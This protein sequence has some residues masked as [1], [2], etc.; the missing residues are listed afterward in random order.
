[1]PYYHRWVRHLYLL[2]LFLSGQTFADQ[3]GI[4]WKIEGK[5]AAPSYLLGTIHSE[6]PQVLQVAATVSPQLDASSSFTAEMDLGLENAFAAAIS[7]MIQDG[8]ELP[9]LIGQTRYN[10][11]VT[12]LTGYG[13]PEMMARQL[14]PWAVMAQ[15][16]MP[17]SKTGEF[18]DRV[19]YQRAQ[20]AHK[21]VYGLET[22]E[23]QINVFDQLSL[24]QQIALLDDALENFPRLDQ[25]LHTLLG[26]YLQRDLPGLQQYSEKL[27]K[28]SQQDLVN[29]FNQRLLIDRNVRMADRMQARLQEGNAFIAVGA[30]HLPGEKGL[31][32]LLA[33]RGYRVTPVY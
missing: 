10:K 13:V 17:K 7:M 9:Q 31:L 18:L 21:P 27:N 19:L 30:L 4:L 12:L 1:M 22:F 2:L 24:Q 3:Q 28:K 11:C 16:S 26:L 32:R 20:Q 14:K 6:D 23:E 29:T 8:K 25:Q 15:L 5:A 33:A